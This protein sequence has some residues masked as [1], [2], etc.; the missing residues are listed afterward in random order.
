M[1]EF[2]S[3]SELVLAAEKA[4]G[5][6]SRATSTAGQASSGTPASQASSGTPRA[7]KKRTRLLVILRESKRSW[8]A[9][10]WLVKY[11][12]QQIR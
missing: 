11:L 4:R 8:R 12:D 10:T 2:H 6:P 3:L 5:A 9:A 7:A 1:S